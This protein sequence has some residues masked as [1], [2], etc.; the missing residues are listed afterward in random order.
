MYGY[1]LL[2]ITSATLLLSAC[3]GGG[4][5]S[6]K[7]DPQP[8]TTC[9]QRIGTGNFVTTTVN[10]PSVTDSTCPTNAT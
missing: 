9:S 2:L 7:P 8:S 5:G 4:G 3:G 6:T 1:R 10:N